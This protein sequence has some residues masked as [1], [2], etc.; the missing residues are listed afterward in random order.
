MPLAP[1]NAVG[2]GRLR[3]RQ[4]GPWFFRDERMYLIPGDSAMAIACRS[5]ACRGRLEGDYPY[6]IDGDTFDPRNESACGR[7]FAERWFWRG[8]ECASDGGDAG[9]APAQLVP[10]NVVSHLPFVSLSNH[11]V[12]HRSRR[13]LNSRS[14]FDRLTTTGGEH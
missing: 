1:G 6:F 11:R 5:T 10:Q 13:H 14:W 9:L 8:I 4:T 12:A 7:T 2:P 3:R